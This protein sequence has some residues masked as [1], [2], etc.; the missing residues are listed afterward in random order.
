M[1]ITMM[2]M[3]IIIITIAISTTGPS[4][5]LLGFGASFGYRVYGLLKVRLPKL[6]EG[7]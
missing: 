2:M 5:G 3:I 1:I 4:F 6:S 7:C